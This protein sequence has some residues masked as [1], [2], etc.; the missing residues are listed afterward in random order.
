MKLFDLIQKLIDVYD[1]HGNIDVRIYADYEQSYEFATTVDQLYLIDNYL[2]DKKELE[3]Y[4][5]VTGYVCD[6]TEKCA[7]IWGE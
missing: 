4:I 1:E 5:D 2:F 6:G 7:I 3:E